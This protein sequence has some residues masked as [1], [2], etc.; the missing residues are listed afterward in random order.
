M[1][2]EYVVKTVVKTVKSVVESVV[3]SF[4]LAG[5]PCLGGA[6]GWRR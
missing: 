2:S 5:G 1:R 4:Q 6:G 3:K